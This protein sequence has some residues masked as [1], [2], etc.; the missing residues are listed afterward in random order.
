MD[1]RAEGPGQ[2]ILVLFLGALIIAALGTLVTNGDMRGVIDQ[3]AQW[4]PVVI[5]I[6]LIVGGGAAL[7]NS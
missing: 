3:G 6:A 4:A 2:I 5:I 1:S 7:A